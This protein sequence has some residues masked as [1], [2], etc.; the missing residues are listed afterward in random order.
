M[1]SRFGGLEDGQAAGRVKRDDK[2]VTNLDIRYE[3]VDDWCR[4]P[5]PGT[6]CSRCSRP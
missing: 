5:G 1:I 4:S 2:G 6:P 3:T